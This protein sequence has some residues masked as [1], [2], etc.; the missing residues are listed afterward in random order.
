MVRRE[1]CKSR[2]PLGQDFRRQVPDSHK[3]H[4]S[5]RGETSAHFGRS[6]AESDLPAQQIS[7]VSHALS[8]HVESVDVE[9]AR[10]WYVCQPY[11]F[12]I[13]SKIRQ[14][15]TVCIRGGNECQVCRLHIGRKHHE[16]GPRPGVFLA[17]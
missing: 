5:N 17:L 6:F 3:W 16:N 7:T 14:R 9:D 2:I 1:E 11:M 12:R 8:E 10:A 13:V 15:E 4:V